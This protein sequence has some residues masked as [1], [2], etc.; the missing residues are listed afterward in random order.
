M[1]QQHNKKQTFLQGA[2][3][4]LVAN[5]MVKVIGA[6]FK[7]P[8]QHLLLDEG[9][10]VF[11]VAYQ[12]YTAMFVIS[13]AGVPVALSKMVSESYTLGRNR[14]IRSIIRI[15]GLVFITLGVLC[16]AF[17]YFG[18]EWLGDLIKNPA[19]VLSMKAV[20]PSVFFVACISVVRGYYQGKSNM[21]PTALSQLAE[22]L[23]KLFLGLGFAAF[24]MYKGVAVEVCTAL[25]IL[26]I[27]I[28]EGIAA[29]GIWVYYLRDPERH[30]RSMSH[31]YRGGK[32][33]VHNLLWL[34]IP[35]TLTNSVTSLTT[36]VDT[37]MVVSRLQSIGYS[38]SEA[39]ELFGMYNG[40][41]FTMYNLPQTLIAALAISI[42]PAIAGAMAQKNDTL[43]AKNLGS[44]MRI[45]MLIALPA[46]T[47]YFILAKPI[48][49]MLFAGD[50]NVGGAC[51][52]VLAFA[53]PFVALVSLT[54]A[55]L[56]AAGRV[57]VP[58]ISML[59]GG[60]IKVV[61]N[62]TLVGVPKINI[63]G[64]PFGTVICYAFITTVNLI[65]LRKYV[66]LPKLDKLILR[67]MAACLGMG[68][69]AYIVYRLVSG[70]LGN[71]VGVMLAICVAGVIYL[72]LLLALGALEK[73]DVM[74][75]PKGEK[76]V[77]L[78]HLK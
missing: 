64:A 62:Y 21:M 30:A 69:G 6:L 16:S 41:A 71:T 38:L 56:Q 60:V 37:T 10:G 2:I 24:G 27:T 15:A 67:P 32:Q 25:A 61:V 66:R 20:A 48:I 72:T 22:A 14:E 39:N 52:R 12:F 18:A 23:G 47:G 11:N 68:A 43:T 35:I 76:L 17:L 53:I 31:E 34:V 63:Y 13:T 74:M 7:I 28:G 73:D 50:P 55:V 42:V 8:L 45:A 49:D 1:P 46:G 75:M 9:M 5:L 54:N 26:G 3:I 36:L 33:L 77:R 44:A 51:L 59:I 40:K 19:A 4:L 58:V 29:L 57:R 70:L 65:I 78:L